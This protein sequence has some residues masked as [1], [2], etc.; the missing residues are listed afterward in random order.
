MAAG[1]HPLTGIRRVIAESMERSWAIPHIHGF[2]EIDATELLAARDRLRAAGGDTTARLSV[3]P[4]MVMAVAQALRRYPVVNASIDTAAGTITVHPDVNVGVA[5]ATEHGL[6]VPVVRQADRRGLLDLAVEIDRLAT[7]A[8]AR[9]IAV[10]DLRHG[11]CT[12]TNYGSLGGGRYAAPIIR[13]PEVAIVGFG[14]IAARPIVVDGEVV[15][16]PTLP[17]AVG[18]DHRLV[19]GDLSGAFQRQVS[20]LLADP[21]ALLLER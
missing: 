21:V 19:D 6:V 3:L 13:A 17:I 20:T 12:V 4:L 15:A 9:T 14:A 2:D 1:V 10:D 5:V 18:A 8:R 16:R 7:A 11:T